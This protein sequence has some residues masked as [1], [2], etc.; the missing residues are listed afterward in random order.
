MIQVVSG[1]GRSGEPT[2]RL[3]LNPTSTAEARKYATET[4]QGVQKAY[5]Y[6]RAVIWVQAAIPDPRY[7]ISIHGAH[8]QNLN[9]PLSG[10]WNVY[11]GA[12]S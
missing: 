12:R 3:I 11:R 9:E 8:G 10:F 1:K 4:C 6:V 2:L 7:F 5:G